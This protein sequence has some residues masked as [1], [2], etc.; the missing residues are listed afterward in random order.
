MYK[1]WVTP[2]NQFL[3]DPNLVDNACGHGCFHGFVP[4]FS[5]TDNFKVKAPGQPPTACM[6]VYKFIDANGN[7]IREPG[8]GELRIGGWGFFVFDPLGAQIN[9]KMFT[10][11]GFK[12]CMLFNLTPGKYR[13]VEDATDGSGTFLVTA[14][15]VDTT[16]QNPVDLEIKVTFTNNDLRHDV[17]FGNQKQ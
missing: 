9:G 13:I 7:G 8:S 6:G 16:N 4:A 10:I 17:F 3:G 12:D 5:K 2:T 11:A 1:A 14:N 15:I